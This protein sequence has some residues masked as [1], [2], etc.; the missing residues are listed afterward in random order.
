MVQSQECLDGWAALRDAATAGSVIYV[1]C[2]QLHRMRL[3]PPW[4]DLYSSCQPGD[5]TIDPT[6]QPRSGMEGGWGRWG[7]QPQTPP[8]AADVLHHEPPVHGYS[9]RIGPQWYT[10]GQLELIWSPTFPPY[11]A[12]LVWRSCEQGFMFLWQ[13]CRAT[14]VNINNTIYSSTFVQEDIGSCLALNACM[15]GLLVRKE[16]KCVWTGSLVKPV[17][18]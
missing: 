13:G 2:G 14:F 12:P 8:A 3:L 16:N 18:C 17:S 4:G 5:S 6:T 10:Q 9:Y 7:L 1:Y 15:S 11:L